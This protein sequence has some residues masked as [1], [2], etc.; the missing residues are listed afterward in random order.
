[1]C[2]PLM[3]SMEVK[4]LVV[5]WYRAGRVDSTIQRIWQWSS[6]CVV[7]AP[8]LRSI[9]S[10]T[11]TDAENDDTA[12]LRAKLKQRLALINAVKN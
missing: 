8:I 3:A 9:L 7:Y 4:G 6:S 2:D 1:M 11:V 5:F 10:D 12:L